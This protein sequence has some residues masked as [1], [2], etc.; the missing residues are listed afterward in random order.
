MLGS[1]RGKIGRTLIVQHQKR[2]IIKNKAAGGK[3]QLGDD[4]SA[5]QQPALMQPG[6]GG[7]VRY[8]HPEILEALGGYFDN[9]AVAATN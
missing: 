4:H 8:S 3:D 5:K 1:A 7:G 9:P 6:G 2:L